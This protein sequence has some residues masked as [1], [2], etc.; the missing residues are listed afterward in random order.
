MENIN[1]KPGV[2]VGIMILKDNKVLLGKRHDDPENCLVIEDGISGMIAANRAK[3]KCIGLVKDL[4]QSY[5]VKNII[6]SLSEITQEYLDQIYEN[7]N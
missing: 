5:P 2:G 3:M 6:T 4:N 1:K 7:I